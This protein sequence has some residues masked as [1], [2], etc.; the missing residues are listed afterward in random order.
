MTN[1]LLR[2]STIGSVLAV[3]R[4]SSPS[5]PSSRTI[6]TSRQSHVALQAPSDPGSEVN[7]SSLGL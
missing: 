5:S 1:A 2:S 7:S 6:D 3:V 4:G